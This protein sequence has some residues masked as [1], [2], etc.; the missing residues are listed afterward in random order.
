MVGLVSVSALSWYQSQAVS[1]LST[2][3][4]TFFAAHLNSHL[5]VLA[6]PKRTQ[7]RKGGP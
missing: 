1:S 3:R 5:T 4:G 7:P 2:G 6:Q